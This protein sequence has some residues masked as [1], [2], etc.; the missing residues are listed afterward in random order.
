MRAWTTAASRS[1]FVG[2]RPTHQNRCR[3]FSSRPR[4]T[5][6]TQVLR[7]MLNLPSLVGG[8]STAT[9]KAPSLLEPRF[10]FGDLELDAAE[11]HGVRHTLSDPVLDR[12]HR[13]GEVSSE[14]TLVQP[15]T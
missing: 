5:R 13:A 6:P 15:T 12:P 4:N 9:L 10:D 3:P 1:R 14:A 8:Q 2:N 11:D 7:G